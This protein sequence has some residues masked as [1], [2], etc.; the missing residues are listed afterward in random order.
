MASL[1]FVPTPSVPE[2]KTGSSMP[3]RSSP[4]QPPKP[5]TS[6]RQPDVFV[7][8]MWLFISSTDLYPAV[9]STPAAAYDFDCE[10]FIAVLLIFGNFGFKSVFHRGRRYFGRVISVKAGGA[11]ARAVN[12]LCNLFYAFNA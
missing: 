9:I 5:P 3:L 2:T 8:A 7:L 6:S 10:L 11:V 4:K 1:I 12:A